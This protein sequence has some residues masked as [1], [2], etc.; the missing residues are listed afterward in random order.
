MG[1]PTA[2]N[3]TAGDGGRFWLVGLDG[4]RHWPPLARVVGHEDWLD[5]PR[6][7]TP[8]ARFKNAEE[9]IRLLDEV[10]ATRTLAEWSDI[11]ATEPDVFWAP[12]QTIDDLISDEQFHAAGGL[13]D[14]PDRDGSTTTMLSTP[15]DFDGRQP[16]PTGLAPTLG[17]H[18]DEI[19]AE[20]GYSAREV[21]ELRTKGVV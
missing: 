13:V 7:A 17:E 14:V 9:L 15:V 4:Q 2:N 10:F 21:A 19:L 3:Y 6:F 8:G 16:S 11:F 20:L 18:T 5:D 1:N 12:V